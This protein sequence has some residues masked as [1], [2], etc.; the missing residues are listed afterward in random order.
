MLRLGPCKKLGMPWPSTM[1][2]GSGGGGGGGAEEV[3]AVPK[4][5]VEGRRWRD[6]CGISTTSMRHW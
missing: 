5:F 1:A 4:V 2:R 6:S 3:V